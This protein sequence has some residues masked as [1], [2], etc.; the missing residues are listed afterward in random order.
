[1]ADI[2]GHRECNVPD[3]STQSPAPPPPPAAPRSAEDLHLNLPLLN[4]GGP[5]VRRDGSGK[6]DNPDSFKKK[7]RRRKKKKHPIKVDG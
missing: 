1:V 4:L 2:Q 5:P 3:I 7:H 6:D